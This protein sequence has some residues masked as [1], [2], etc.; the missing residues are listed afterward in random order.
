[1]LTREQIDVAVRSA[2]TRSAWED[3]EP[4]AEQA[5]QAAELQTELLDARGWIAALLEHAGSLGSTLTTED[6]APRAAAYQA[7]MDF[8]RGALGDCSAKEWQ[9]ARDRFEVALALAE[10]K[11]EK[12]DA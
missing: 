6:L 7:A 3:L 1:M 8:A 4:V 2:C 11:G 5:A 9:A 10:G 12:H